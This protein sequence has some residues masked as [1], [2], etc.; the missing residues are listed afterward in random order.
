MPLSE[1]GCRRLLRCSEILYLFLIAFSFYLL[2][3]SRTGEA[4][5]VWEALNPAFIPVL[6]VASSI[7]IPIL[8]TSEK[9]A[10]KLLFIIVHS[11][12]IHSLFSIIFPAGD[13]S[14]QQEALGKTRLIY[15]NIVLHGANPLPFRSLQAEI[16][17]RFGGANFQ[18]A[19]SVIFAR[20]LSID[21]MW[22]HLF[23][24]P[25]L[26][27]VF[28][29]IAAFLT[30]KA[31]SEDDKVSVLSGLLISVF[32]Y[33][34]YF[35]AISVSVSLGYIF[36]FYSLYFM[37][38]Y[39]TSNDSKTTA[40]MLAFSFFA[41][42]A[43]YLTG[44]MAFS[45]LFLTIAFKA[46]ASEKKT[47]SKITRLTLAISIIISA[48]LLPLSLIYLRF[49]GAFQ[50]FFTWDKFYDLSRGEIVGLFLLGEL[51]HGFDFKTILLIVIGPAIALLW[52]MYLLYRFKRNS[53][54]KFRVHM[55]FLF[56]AFLIILID[57][58]ILKVFMKGVQELF[59][60]ERLWVF[61][62]FIAAPFVAL[63][64]FAAV[65]S[66]KAFLKA[67]SPRN[68]SIA[69][70]KTIRACSKA[71]SKRVVPR[72]LGLFFAGLLFTLTV[73][74]PLL[75][76]GW[77]TTSLSAAY[78]QVA[79]LQITWYELEAV[80]YIEEKTNEKYVVICDIWTM[81]AGEMIV[82]F[83]NP[84]A[85]YFESSKTGHDL[86]V[87]MTRKPSPQWMLSA[88]NY[89][90]TTVAYYIASEPRLGTE[91]FNNVVSKARDTLTVFHV[92]GNGKLYVF[93]YKK[94]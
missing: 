19:L 30:A 38:K 77:M 82:G 36:F 1:Q 84:S 59:N 53:T 8:L 69:S 14:G 15:D 4:R 3:L 24:V 67:R 80:K 39:L 5:T 2:V 17:K 32:P 23:L 91:E 7:L 64:I 27:G 51:I 34:T 16:F 29:P 58:R 94:G 33:A 20:M 54:A 75:L 66:L 46:Y 56:T 40:L 88:M 57:Y 11:I 61:R 86:F 22:V 42:L 52:M 76:A 74:F 9:T 18:A 71:P 90:N 60:E 83:S 81:Y 62:D 6:F 44:V 12:L 70:S 45:L 79:P 49:F 89:T 10:Y 78:P 21:V 47:S 65:S 26:W 92:T 31:I 50:I 43:H 37:L 85:Y 25:V 93:S 68:L 35:G 41:L 72:V 63:A 28:V 73:F 87:N 55:Y 48:I 13:L